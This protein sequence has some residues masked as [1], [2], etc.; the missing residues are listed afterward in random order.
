NYVANARDSFATLARR[1]HVQTTA[2]RLHEALFCTSC[3]SGVGSIWDHHPRA[4]RSEWYHLVAASM[5]ETQ[6]AAQTT[7]CT[8]E[9]QRVLTT[10]A[11]SLAPMM[12]VDIDPAKATLK[13]LRMILQSE[14]SPETTSF[15]NVTR[16][17]WFKSFA[18]P[19]Y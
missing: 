15:R 1:Q 18:D 4:D 14:G 3:R 6:L 2:R 11:D 9:V 19:V 10:V 16:V 17:G 13:D 8:A 7:S 5:G 12:N